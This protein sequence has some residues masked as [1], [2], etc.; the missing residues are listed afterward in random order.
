MQ[1]RWVATPKTRH[2]LLL[3][4]LPR[5]SSF[6]ISTAA[7]R[8]SYSFTSLP[9][10]NRAYD[11]R[12]FSKVNPLLT[13][14]RF[15]LQRSRP[16]Q[17]LLDAMSSS[18]A[19]RILNADSHSAPSKGR[20]HLVNDSNR[21]QSP[22]VVYDEDVKDE[23]GAADVS[24][25]DARPTYKS[26]KKKYRKMRIQFDMLQ[27]QN[28]ELYQLE[29]KALRKTKQLASYNDRL[30]E[31]LLDINNRPQIPIEKRFDLSLP[32]ASATE[33]DVT[34]PLDKE[35]RP[36]P[37]PAKLLRELINDVPHLDF[38][39]TAERYPEAAHDL[40]APVDSPAF[41]TNHQQQPPP[42]LTA[43]DMDNYM[44]EID[45]K[46]I[47]NPDTYGELPELLTTWAPVA[48]E[49][50]AGGHAAGRGATPSLA[51]TSGK[52][53]AASGAGRGG[54]SSRDFALRN[55]TSVYNWLRKHAPRTFLQDHE[56]GDD[57]KEKSAEKSSRK[58]H[59]ADDD[60]EDEDA[61]PSVRKST[62]VSGRKASGEGR[63]S[64]G[65]GR[66]NAKGE[67]VSKRASGA[68]GK[69]KRKIDEPSHGLGDE[70]AVGK[71]SAANKS[72]RKRTVDDDTGYR[73][74][75]GSSRRPG[76]KRVKT[77]LGGGA[78]NEDRIEGS[79]QLDLAPAKKKDN[80][81]GASDEVTRKSGEVD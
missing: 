67:R 26:W 33:E 49:L 14:L 37:R 57:K 73:P 64:T 48:R 27:T 46:T 61:R 18:F 77:S 29:Q 7:R 63:A 23:D 58:A 5:L 79:M 15:S 30:L 43:E 12:S 34:L 66:A 35:P 45:A 53:A 38:A 17:A 3:S 21:T 2:Q 6:G 72:K 25:G 19:R 28:E 65:S 24:M 44:W 75:G 39:T 20:S 32:I 69:D 60:A 1:L 80:P 71:T 42:F 13:L 40:I 11:T 81:R 52:E 55:P 31:V 50:S 62:G 76:K 10:I 16:K 41:D 74:K 70:A 4:T 54:L 9:A 56:G 59:R 8:D 22:S 78:G 47:A 36:G 51:V 68:H